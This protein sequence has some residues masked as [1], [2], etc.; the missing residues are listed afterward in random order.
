MI[1]KNEEHALP[2]LAESLRG[3][4]DYWTIVDTGSTDKTIA[5]VPD[6]FGGV[7]GELITTEWLGYGPSRNVS[8]DAAREHTDWLLLLD[9]DHTLSGRIDRDSLTDRF[10]SILVEE[11]YHGL[12]LWRPFLIR[13][14]V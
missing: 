11:R 6:L 4:F 14:A 2:R 5:M 9:A 1:V 12:R 8:L 3:Q 7:S 13:S 10:D